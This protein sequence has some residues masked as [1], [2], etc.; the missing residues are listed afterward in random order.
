MRTP[1]NP[2]RRK[3]ET[4]PLK[5]T[6]QDLI[7]AYQLQGKLAETAI[8]ADWEQLMGR[9]VAQKTTELYFQNRKLF[10]RIASAPLRHQLYLGRTEILRRVNEH[11]GAPNGNGVVEVVF[12]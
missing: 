10:V 12:L 5:D 2:N 9:P 8:I 1:P 3:A 6:L 4:Q 7:R 11:G